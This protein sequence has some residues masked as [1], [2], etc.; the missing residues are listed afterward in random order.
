MQFRLK[1]STLQNEEKNPH[2]LGM[3]KKFEY[4]AKHSHDTMKDL[5]KS[6]Q[7]EEELDGQLKIM[8]SEVQKK[9][10]LLEQSLPALREQY[11]QLVKQVQGMRKKHEE[12]K[13]KLRETCRPMMVQKL[14]SYAQEPVVQMN[15]AEDVL[16]NITA[17][18]STQDISKLE[19]INLQIGTRTWW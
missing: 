17:T 7:H 6:K 15:T 13:E 11:L 18:T 1:Q 2:L 8:E 12:V 4:E 3:E 14:A 9:R 16:R 5:L 19:S 10:D